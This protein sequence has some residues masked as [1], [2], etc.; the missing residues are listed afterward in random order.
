MTAAVYC[1]VLYCNVLY[2]TV[3]Y[4]TVLYRTVLYCTVLYCTILAGA[5][6]EGPIWSGKKLENLGTE[7]THA[8]N[9]G[10]RKLR[11]LYSSVDSRGS[12]PIHGEYSD[13]WPVSMTV[14]WSGIYTGHFMD[15]DQTNPWP[16][17]GNL[18]DPI[19]VLTDH[20]MISTLLA[21]IETPIKRGLLR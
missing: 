9:Q 7:N 18:L 2:S 11:P 3:L 1:T 13:Y 19:F 10:I 15:W 5:G 21:L 14:Y 4:C 6:F 20:C 8:D 12:G 17:V 16:I